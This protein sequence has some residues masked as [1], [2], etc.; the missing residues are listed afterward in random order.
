MALSPIRVLVTRRLPAEAR[1]R[2]DTWAAAVRPPAEITGWDSDE[3]MP[4][5]ELLSRVRGMTGV[6]CLLTDRIDADAYAAAGSGLR[7]VSNVAVG[8]D[9]I[10]IAEATRRGVLV[11]NTPGVLTETT[12]DLAWALILAAC[13]RLPEAL[14]HLREER[15][16]TWRTLELA[17]L[18]VYGATLGVVGA[19]RIGQAV[20]RRATG[21]GMRV[22]YHSRS[23]HPEFEAALARSEAAKAA[24]PYRP[25]LDQLLSESDIITLHVPLTPETHHLIGP[26]QLARMKPTAVLVNTAR[27]AVV[28][29]AALA[30][31]LAE[32]RIFA[33]GLDVYERE[34]LPTDSPLRALDNVVLLPHVGSATIR[35]R[36]RMAI[37]AVESLI[38]ALGGERPATAVNA[39]DL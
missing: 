28:D 37:L 20:A 26:D 22:L 12:A 1:A 38:A 19:G 6:I 35:T 24:G 3:P 32:R 30:R 33:A 23:R 4:R 25:C 29:E 2:L 17:G 27:G 9:N 34:P 21:F 7:V 8:Y 13:R 39:P 5:A 15:W 11:T 10:D 36:T 18:D 16:K 14:S 31:A